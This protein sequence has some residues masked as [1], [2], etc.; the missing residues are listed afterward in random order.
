MVE[1]G[2]ACDGLGLV[3]ASSDVIMQALVLRMEPPSNSKPSLLAC[4][5]RD[6]M[7][8]P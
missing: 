7:V 3:C 4:I 1:L 8:N 2:V 6:F 5:T